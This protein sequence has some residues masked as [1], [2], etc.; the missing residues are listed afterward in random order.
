MVNFESLDCEI[1]ERVNWFEVFTAEV[2]LD[3]AW[4]IKF[5]GFFYGF[6]MNYFIVSEVI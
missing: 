4:L 1:G 2:V 3:I 5:S 6:P